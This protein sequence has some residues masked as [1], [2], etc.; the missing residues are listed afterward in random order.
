MTWLQQ[1]IDYN[2]PDAWAGAAADTYSRLK[3]G[4]TPTPGA[5]LPAAPAPAGPSGAS[6]TP[7]AADQANAGNFEQWKA[8]TRQ[9]IEDAIKNGSYNPAGNF[10]F[11]AAWWATYGPW[12]A[13]AAAAG[14]LY[15]VWKV[16]RIR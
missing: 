6:W 1:F 2:T 14:A 11:D 9:A 13:A 7:A 16:Y 4:T 8:E 5:G 15:V 3:Y 12:I 10:N